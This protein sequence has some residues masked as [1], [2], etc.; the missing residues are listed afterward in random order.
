MASHVV[1]TANSVGSVVVSVAIGVFAAPYI[2][3]SAVAVRDLSFIVTSVCV[4]CLLFDHTSTGFTYEML[5]NDALALVSL[6]FLAAAVGGTLGYLF[7]RTFL[8][9]KYAFLCVVGCAF[10]NTVILPVGIISTLDVE[11][12]T[13]AVRRRAVTLVFVYNIAVTISFWTIGIAFIR[14]AAAKLHTE[15]GNAHDAAMAAGGSGGG[16]VVKTLISAVWNPPLMA[17][18]L[19]IACGI[20]DVRRGRLAH[21]FQYPFTSI[22]SAVHFIAEASVPASLVILGVNLRSSFVGLHKRFLAVRRRRAEQTSP[23]PATAAPVAVTSTGPVDKKGG[24]DDGRSPPPLLVA[25]MITVR[26][27]IIPFVCMSA[28]HVARRAFGLK[29]DRTANLVLFVELTAPSAI[30]TG[31]IC[32]VYRYFPIEFSGALFYQYLVVVVTAALWL[33]FTLWYI[34]NTYDA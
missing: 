13:D 16:G 15:E 33:I 8:P 29:L 32:N 28:F 23:A 4:P 7:G 26:L 31:L 14:R 34:D 20:G 10:Q 25:C 2:P 9:E 21:G 22:F 19:G 24:E 11:W 27:L 1:A 6:A 5:Q 18:F 3:N 30:G 17:T 12:I